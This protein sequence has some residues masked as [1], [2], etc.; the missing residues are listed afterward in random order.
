VQHV[1]RQHVLVFVSQASAVSNVST[2]GMLALL[3]AQASN[4]C[5]RHV[6]LPRK[7]TW[8][9]ISSLTLLCASAG[10]TPACTLAPRTA[11]RRSAA[12][13]LSCAPRRS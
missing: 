5:C 13:P 11:A 3:A 1:R 12:A 10:A 6:A 2:R 8:L 9:L 7:F 4:L